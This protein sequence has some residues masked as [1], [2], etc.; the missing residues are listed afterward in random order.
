MRQKGKKSQSRGNCTV[1]GLNARGPGDRRCFRDWVQ[2]D[3]VQ[4]RGN[5]WSL[6]APLQTSGDSL[7]CPVR[8]QSIS[9]IPPMTQ[10]Y[11][12]SKSSTPGEQAAGER[13]VHGAGTHSPTNS[14]SLQCS[15]WHTASCV[16]LHL[17][18]LLYWYYYI[19]R[20]SRFSFRLLKRNTGVWWF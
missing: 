18:I 7:C 5:F 14:T 16:Y 20:T 3:E 9:N 17:C 6:D 4:G 13:G 12:T 10:D 2:F 15:V 19:L 1:K 8:A 11:R